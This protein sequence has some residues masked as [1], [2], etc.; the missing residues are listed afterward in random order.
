MVKYL[1]HWNVL[2]PCHLSTNCNLKL[3]AAMCGQWTLRSNGLLSVFSASCRTCRR[4]CS[5][6]WRTLQHTWTG[7]GLPWSPTP[8]SMMPK[9]PTPADHACIVHRQVLHLR[10]CLMPLRSKSF[11][12]DDIVPKTNKKCPRKE[13]NQSGACRSR[14][15]P[16]CLLTWN[17]SS[18]SWEECQQDLKKSFYEALDFLTFTGLKYC[19]YSYQKVSE[20]LLWQH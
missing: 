18:I 7:W 5:S 2:K 19:W 12:D 10:L 11:N 8:L 14:R 20:T 9:L 1:V 3:Y 15:K 4:T 6:P 13:G 17:D 16:V